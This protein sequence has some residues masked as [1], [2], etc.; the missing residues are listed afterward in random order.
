MLRP[1][2]RAAS[3]ADGI[4]FCLEYITKKLADCPAMKGG[5]IVRVGSEQ[6]PKINRYLK[7]PGLASWLDDTGHGVW[8]ASGVNLL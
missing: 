4:Y 6:L 8:M 5:A 1:V 2:T 7:S 3:C